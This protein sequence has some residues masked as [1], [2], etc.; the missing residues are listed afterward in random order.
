M[1]RP[2]G[3]VP[4][5]SVRLMLRILIDVLY[6]VLHSKKLPYLLYLDASIS[7]LLSPR[8]CRRVLA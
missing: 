7:F 8:H 1:I 5:A 3:S 4:D 6:I 2:R